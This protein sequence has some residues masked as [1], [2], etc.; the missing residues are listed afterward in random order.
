M[1]KCQIRNIEAGIIRFDD[2]SFDKYTHCNLFCSFAFDEYAR[3]GKEP[4]VITSESAIGE[5]I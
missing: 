1:D 5:L 3:N 4:S 2:A